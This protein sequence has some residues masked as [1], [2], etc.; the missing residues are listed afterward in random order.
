M[1]ESAYIRTRAFPLPPLPNLYI[2]LTTVDSYV[3]SCVP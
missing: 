3:P 1:L 2:Y